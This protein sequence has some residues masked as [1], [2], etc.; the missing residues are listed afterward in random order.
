MFQKGNEKSGKSLFFL[1]Y[2]CLKLLR[3]IVYIATDILVIGSQC[4]KKSLKIRLRQ[5]FSNSIYLEFMGK[6][7]NSGVALI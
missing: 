2:L 6:H 5:A 4:A 7:D 1:S 3:E